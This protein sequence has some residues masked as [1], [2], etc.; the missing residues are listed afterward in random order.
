MKVGWKR[1][2]RAAIFAFIQSNQVTY[3]WKLSDYV[4]VF[5][6]CGFHEESISALLH[7][8]NWNMALMESKLNGH[9]QEQFISLCR[10]F[11]G[12]Y[13]FCKFCLKL[14]K[15][16]TILQQPYLY[17]FV[18]QNNSTFQCSSLVFSLYAKLCF[19]DI[20]VDWWLINKNLIFLCLS[21]VFVCRLVLCLYACAQLRILNS[22]SVYLK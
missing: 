9:S 17:L 18:E 5:S 13:F 15:K 12:I 10:K 14:E 11:S 21:F 22:D 7:T 20:W 1:F 8:D 19:L 4:L 3:V 6:R 16:W 2:V